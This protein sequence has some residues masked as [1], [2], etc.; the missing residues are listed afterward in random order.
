MDKSNLR[1]A[2]LRQYLADDPGDDFSEYALALEL[3]KAGNRKDAIIHLENILARNPDYLAAYFQ[4]G[5]FY[6]LEN[7]TLKAT[8]CYTKGMEV[9]QR[10]GN[11]RTLN[12]L[13]SASEMID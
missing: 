11:T 4:C 9:A 13:R 6:E 1:I 7:E 2:M 8:V 10:Q 3:E 5:K 12:E